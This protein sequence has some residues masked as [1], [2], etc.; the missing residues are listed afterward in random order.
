MFLYSL[1]TFV[2]K[3]GCVITRTGRFTPENVLRYL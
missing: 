3:W 2:T 1:L